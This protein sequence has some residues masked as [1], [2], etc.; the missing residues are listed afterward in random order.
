MT[1]RTLPALALMSLALIGT[2]GC[3]TTYH[4]EKT[5]EGLQG[6]RVTVGTVQKEIR[7]GMSSVA[8]AEQLGSPNIVQTDELGREIWIYDKIASDAVSSSGPLILGFGSGGAV[9]KSQRTLTVII[10]FNKD[11]TVRDYAYHA[12][13]F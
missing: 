4:A 6:D 2:T 10:K 7:V 12:S 8:V 3:S 11:M 1:I 5:Q 9:S 13:R